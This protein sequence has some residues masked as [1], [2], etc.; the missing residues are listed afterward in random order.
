M[1]TYW[2]WLIL[3]VAIQF[4]APA[5][6]PKG[7]QRGKLLTMPLRK[8]VK[9]FDNHSCRTK[10]IILICVPTDFIGH[11]IIGN[12]MSY[13]YFLSIIALFIDDWLTN[14]DD[15]KRFGDFVR[16]KIKWKMKLPSPV[17]AGSKVGS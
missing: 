2:S 8:R 1:M 7:Y 16:N 14:H 5:A 10:Q 4:I 15:F 9:F 13:I 17:P 11:M 6:N 12:F 3:T